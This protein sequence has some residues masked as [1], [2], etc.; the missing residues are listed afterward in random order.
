MNSALNI[1]IRGNVSI[2]AASVLLKITNTTF[3]KC[4]EAERLRQISKMII[5]EKSRTQRLITQVSVTQ[6]K[7]T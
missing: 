6:K 7:T 1:V 3:K 5:F 2:R 4:V